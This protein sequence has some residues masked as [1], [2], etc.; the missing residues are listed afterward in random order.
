MI[1]DMTPQ[2]YQRVK[3]V[4]LAVC[5]RPAADQAA[6]A[7]ELCGGDAELCDEVKSL[8]AEKNAGQATA[9]TV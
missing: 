8:L 7:Q 1:L 6:A 9:A 2:R 5:D 4:F 3:E